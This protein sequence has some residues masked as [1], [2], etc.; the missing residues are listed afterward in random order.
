MSF[1][2]LLTVISSLAQSG[3]FKDMTVPL[4]I[5]A[6][7]EKVASVSNQYI[8]MSFVRCGVGNQAIACQ[9]ELASDGSWI[10]F[11]SNME[12]N[13]V[14]LLTAAPQKGRRKFK[15]DFRAWHH[16][17]SLTQ[18]PYLAGTLSEAI[19][20]K[21]AKTSNTTIRVDYVTRGHHTIT[22]WW[23][24]RPDS[25]HVELRIDFTAAQDGYYSLGVMALHQTMPDLVSNILLPPLYQYRRI[26]L[27][28]QMLHTSMMTQPLSIVEATT[29]TGKLSAFVSGD[30]TTFPNEWGC[31]DYSPMGFAVMNHVGMMQPV[32]FSPVIGMSD[33]H[34]QGGQTIQRKFIVGLTSQGWNETLEYISDQVYRVRDY[35]KQEDL[36]LTE[37]LFNII[38]LVKNE[39]YGGWS[40]T[41]KAFY[42]IEGKPTKAP[43]VV[44]SAP[45]AMVGAAVMSH[46]E[47]LYISRALPTIEYTLSRKGYRWST[48][49]AEKGYTSDIENLRFNPFES[50]FTTTYYEG[51][52]SLL[53]KKNSWLK[54][55]ALP[56]DTLRK[57]K[58]YSS[59]ILSWVQAL[60]AWRL[61]GDSKW[62]RKAESAARRDMRLHIYQNSVTPRSFKSFYNSSMYGAWWDL[63]DLYEMSGHKDYLEAARYGAAHTLAG[64]RCFPAV[65]DT[66]QTIHPNNQYEGNTRLWW[67]GMQ[68]FRLGYPRVDGD[69]P[70]KQVPLWKVSPVGLGFEQPSTY[71]LRQRG[72]PVRPVF[73]SSWAPHLLRLSQH[74]GG[75]IYKTYARNAVIGRF[76]NYPGYY[77]T[78]YTD[79]TMQ[80][81]FPYKGPDVSSIYYHHIAPHM[82]FTADFLISEV[83][84]R[85]GGR[86]NFP[87]GKQEGFVWFSNRVYGGAPG[88]VFD[89]KNASLWLKRGLITSSNPAV[90]YVTAISDKTF[91]ILLSSEH[92]DAATTAVSLGREVEE[93]L[94]AGAWEIYDE[95]GK[96]LTTVTHEGTS[97]VV[98]LPAKGMRAVALPLK[99]GSNPFH[100]VAE[101]PTMKGGMKVIDS[102]TQ[103]GKIYIYRIRSPFGWDSVYGFCE[104]P[105]AKGIHVTILCNGER[106]GLDTYPFEWSFMK[107]SPAEQIR[108]KVSVTDAAGK[109]FEKEIAF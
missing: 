108:L 91:W 8:R 34:I 85:T 97:F 57:V 74:T 82:A 16:A 20:V 12:D 3:E 44:H 98:P 81:D 72:K 89:D 66:L 100:M 73:M 68:Q 105:P 54:D 1:L 26:P 31:V 41:M 17:D 56:S 71:F 42:D 58:G 107:Y 9:M 52:N 28:P 67:R 38:E 14:F 43:L 11:T 83:I 23:T 104:T 75:A 5:P 76:A 90:N 15:S 47:E 33:C 63:I 94:A 70:E 60:Y 93:L 109:Q 64:I 53:G 35:R 61:T 65:R 6:G 96:R 84:E 103:A 36:S 78:G 80:A 88:V 79:I 24:L 62:L 99:A 48:Q 69:A 37:T 45:L 21:A 10:P 46:D 92:S 2:S 102:H 25:K 87:Y 95:C 22:G 18:N 77:A 59:R 39:E 30:D 19:P 50:Q 86:V 29:S 51:L 40:P 13:K 7:A 101:V 32:A 106:K 55:I 49:T 4:L 27:Q